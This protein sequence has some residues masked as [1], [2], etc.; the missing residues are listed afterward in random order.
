[1]RIHGQLR[2]HSLERHAL[3]ENDVLRFV[4]R[5][6]RARA[7]FAADD[8]LA[9]LVARFDGTHGT[10]NYEGRQSLVQLSRAI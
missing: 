9:E 3:A 5:R 4:N 2:M 7:D 6:H 10:A 8:V 1:M